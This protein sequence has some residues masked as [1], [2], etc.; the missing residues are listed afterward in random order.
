MRFWDSSAIVTILINEPNTT[1]TSSLLREDHECWI[2]WASRTECLTG[3]H[4]RARAG[5]LTVEELAAARQRLA[6]F[7]RASATVLPAESVRSRADR[8]L[9]LHPLRAA[10]AFQLAAALV[11]SEENPEDL[12][13]VTL[14]ER[15]VEAARKEGFEVLPA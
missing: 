8:L 1:R 14:D 11:A 13:F 3:L 12:P 5:A 2:W 6:L 9:G 10:D 7:E 15:L 4:R